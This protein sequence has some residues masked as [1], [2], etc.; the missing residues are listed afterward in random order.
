MQEKIINL[1]G[2]NYLVREDGKI[3]STCKF[4][5]SGNPIEIKQR[6]N[7]DGYYTITVGLTHNRRTR[8]VHKIVADAFIPTTDKT[9]EVDHKD[10]NRLNNHLS[11][12]QWISHAQ[13]VSKIPFE[14]KSACRKGSKNGRAKLNEQD[15][16]IIRKMYKD[17]MTIMEIAKRFERGWTTI[18]HVIKGETWTN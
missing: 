16:E 14:R 3:Y 5:D 12:L 8:T 11:N 1:Y 9:L 7:P 18:S 15:A 2:I 4:D 10:D 17:G 13:N 6:L